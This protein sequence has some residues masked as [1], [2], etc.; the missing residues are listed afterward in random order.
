V[1]AFFV[2]IVSN[3]ALIIVLIIKVSNAATSNFVAIWNCKSLPHVAVDILVR[4]LP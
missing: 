3:C 1:Y 2:L 4:M